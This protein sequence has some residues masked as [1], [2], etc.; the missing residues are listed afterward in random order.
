LG[1]DDMFI[2]MSIHRQVDWIKL[3]HEKA[4]DI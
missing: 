1:F 4:I 3:L 2:L